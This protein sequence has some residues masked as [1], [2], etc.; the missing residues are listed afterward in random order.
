MIERG[1]IRNKEIAKQ[2]KDFSNLR[3]ENVTP[4]DIDGFIEFNNCIYILIEAKFL[5]D[6]LPEGQE[7]ALINLVDTIFESSKKGIL[8]IAIHN[9][10][11][12]QDIPFYK[13]LVS[14]YRSRKSWYSPKK[15]MTIKNLIDSYLKK[16]CIDCP[17]INCSAN[18]YIKNKNKI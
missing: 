15:E 10:P 1:K 2:L 6:K 17:Q 7:R 4:T 18:K 14:R 13:C 8:I 12:E 11:L 16:N 5:E 9:Q 3:F